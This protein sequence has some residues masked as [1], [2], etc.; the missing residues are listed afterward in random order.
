MKFL[1]CPGGLLLISSSRI[2]KVIMPLCWL[3]VLPS[4]DIAKLRVLPGGD[5]MSGKSSD[6]CH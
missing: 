4:Q 3:D 5:Y 2:G 1:V 6:Y